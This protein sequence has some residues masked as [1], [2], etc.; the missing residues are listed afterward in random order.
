MKFVPKEKKHISE[1][2]LNLPA[3]TKAPIS[4]TSTKK[5]KVTLQQQRL[6]CKQLENEIEK[7]QKMLQKT[8]YIIDDKLS[9]DFIHIFNT[10]HTC[11]SI[12]GIILATTTKNV[13]V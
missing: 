1:K 4:A 6:K 8:N 5:I 13:S 10:K 9:Q 2:R 7:M 11:D 12:Y 3:K